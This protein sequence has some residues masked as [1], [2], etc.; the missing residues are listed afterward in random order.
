MSGMNV[1]S[2]RL[3]AMAI[4]SAM[5]GLAGILLALTEA[6]T[7]TMILTGLLMATAAAIVGGLGSAAG[8]M[9]GA[10]V[11][12]LSMNIGVWHLPSSWQQAVAFVILLAFILLRPQGLMGSKVASARV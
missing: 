12:A 1:D 3:V 9:I 8:A 5:A 7:L 10:I 6:A 11:I 4:G 2:V